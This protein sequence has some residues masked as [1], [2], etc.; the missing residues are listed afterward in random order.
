M[1]K[2]V[3]SGSTAPFSRVLQPTVVPLRRPLVTPETFSLLHLIMFTIVRSSSTLI[4]R[5]FHNA[6]LLWK[7]QWES[8]DVSTVPLGL[9]GISK[10]AGSCQN[11]EMHGDEQTATRLR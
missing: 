10:G 5:A 11:G 6:L 9:R 4:Q 2:R 3:W 7:K 8:R 1:R